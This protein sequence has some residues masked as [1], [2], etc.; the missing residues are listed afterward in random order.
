ML[1]ELLQ[2]NNKDQD[3]VFKG[4]VIDY[5][6]QLNYI[7]YADP[8]I[9]DNKINADYLKLHYS[10]LSIEELEFLLKEKNKQKQ[11]LITNKIVKLFYQ[12]GIDSCKI[13]N[14]EYIIDTKLTVTQEDAQ[15]VADW[16]KEIKRDDLIK[17]KLTFGKGD[18]TDEIKE[19]ISKLAQFKIDQGI[20]PS[21]LKA[22]IKRRMNDDEIDQADRLPPSDTCSVKTFDIIKIKELG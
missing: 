10:D 6:N 18:F 2:E 1:D 11:D 21:S 20:H 3:P 22:L 12:M 19:K 7:M 9:K 17:T 14:K 13:E 5:V 4:K 8:D 16:L 15:K